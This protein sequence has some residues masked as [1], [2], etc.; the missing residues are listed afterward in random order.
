[1]SVAL[2]NVERHAET[3]IEL[4]VD[5]GPLTGAECC[6]KLGWSRGRFDTALRHAGDR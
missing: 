5:C 2:A 4:L 3:L 1:M 6:E